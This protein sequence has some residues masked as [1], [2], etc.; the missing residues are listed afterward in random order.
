MLLKS[1][2]SNRKI[3]VQYEDELSSPRSISRVT[4]QGSSLSSTLFLV[5]INDLVRA[6]P[7]NTLLFADDTTITIHADSHEAMVE[8]AQE[9]LDQAHAWFKANQLVMHPGKTR[10]M[11]FTSEEEVL[12]TIQDKPIVNVGQDF[13]EKSFKL[14]GVHLDN[15][16][17]F[18]HHVS[19]FQ[20]KVKRYLYGL[21]RI[22]TMLTL[23]LGNFIFTLSSSPTVSMASFSG[24]RK[25][26][27]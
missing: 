3:V 27:I 11:N 14:L 15:K 21:R 26:S 13:Q 23:R 6:V 8:K 12:I 1:Y 2:L 4:P 19:T 18:D 9:A 10:G 22:K 16:L 24:S 17:S 25:Q 7:A 20:G 5:Y